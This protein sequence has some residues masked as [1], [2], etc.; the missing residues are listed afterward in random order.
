MQF[1]IKVCRENH[2]LKVIKCLPTLNQR[3]CCDGTQ[4]CVCSVL[5][6]AKQRQNER[7]GHLH[8]PLPGVSGLSFSGSS[9]GQCLSVIVAKQS[10]M[11][12]WV[13]Y[14]LCQHCEDVPGPRLSGIYEDLQ[15]STDVSFICTT[16]V[17]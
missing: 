7:K 13:S 3:N 11:E 2:T 4:T 15:S 5:N 17:T 6:S 12:T 8:V 1:I 14:R 10:W 9:A 16:Q